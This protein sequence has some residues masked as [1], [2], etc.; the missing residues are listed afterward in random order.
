MRNQNLLLKESTIPSSE[1]AEFHT[2]LKMAEL[3]ETKYLHVDTEANGE[4]I[5]DGRGYC[6]GISVD[7]SP[8]PDLA[9]AYYFPFRHDRG[10][11]DL[12]YRDELKKLIENSGKPM[13]CHN[14]RFDQ[15]SLKTI[16]IT[17]P[18]DDFE[19]TMLLAH[20]VNENLLSYK[21]DYLTKQLGLEGK[22][23]DKYFDMAIKLLGWPGIPP[24][25]MAPYAATDASLLRPLRKYY[26]SLYTAEDD[27]KGEIWK[28]DREFMVLL[29]AI[30]T[31][32]AK[33]NLDLA[34]QKIE[35][36]EKVMADLTK[37]I[38]LNPGS[39]TQLSEL[40]FERI[41]IP[42]SQNHL[43]PKGKPSLDKKAMEYYEDQLTLLN[44]PVARQV[45][46]YRG[47]QKAVS[48]YWKAYLTHVSPD[49]RIRPN[50]NL[51]RTVTHRLSCDTPNLQQ[52]PRITEKPWNKDVKGG[53]IPES[54][55]FVLMEADYSQ[56]EMRLTAAYAK[57]QNLIA[58]FSDAERDLFT[59]MSAALGF[60]RHDVKTGI[61]ATGYG[62]GIQKLD[63]I[64]GKGMGRQFKENY[65]RAYPGVATVSNMAS[66]ACKAQG[67]VKSWTLRR[68]HFEDPYAEAH[69][70]F[71]S[72]IQT[73]SADIVKRIMVR[74]GKEIGLNN[75]ECR[76]IL[77]VHDSV[78]FE[79][80]KSKVDYYGRIIV[81]IMEDVQ[82]NF[83][84][85]FRVDW[86][87]WGH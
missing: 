32:G 22:E 42:V 56:L 15:L 71:N 47:Y 16:G 64:F 69:K 31:A 3:P 87:Q 19:D 45:L 6:I 13:V 5:K 79:I 75:P 23:R 67:Y 65:Y 1:N 9:Y 57:D 84:V 68:R 60:P 12:S 81:K 2:F 49:G 54:D 20:N 27:S 63:T 25:N 70:A 82:P 83:G 77:Q 33:V 76:M 14:W 18:E 36:G 41:G 80:L 4:N 37:E 21:L 58:I 51:H 40:L 73:G 11:L 29:N 74:L 48:S 46:E 72:V 86:H 7:V 61:Y 26:G 28:N 50:F 85:P 35:E 55:D 8:T 30:E 78:V 38:G 59:E 53:F 17:A 43:T 24:E 44:S 34:E 66:A 52:I 10:N 39:T 62:A